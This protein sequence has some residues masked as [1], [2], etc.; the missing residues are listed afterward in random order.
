MFGEEGIPQPVLLRLYKR[1][2]GRECT[3]VLLG[4]KLISQ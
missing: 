4:Q 1:F 2:V 3:I